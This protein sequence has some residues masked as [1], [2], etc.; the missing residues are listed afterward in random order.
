MD[1]T[2]G[3]KNLTID[4]ITQFNKIIGYQYVELVLEN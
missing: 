1:F 2:W 3:I 4:L